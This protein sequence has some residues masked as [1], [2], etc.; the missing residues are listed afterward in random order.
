MQRGVDAAVMWTHEWDSGYGGIEP[1]ERENQT[2]ID[3]TP[4]PPNFNFH[5]IESHVGNY[6]NTQ[7]KIIYC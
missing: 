6:L 2:Q 1:Q 3:Q 5:S 7:F 4:I